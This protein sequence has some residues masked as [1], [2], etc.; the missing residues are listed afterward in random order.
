MKLCAEEVNTGKPCELL[1]IKWRKDKRIIMDDNFSLNSSNSIIRQNTYFWYKISFITF[2]TS[3]MHSSFLGNPC[4]FTF[5]KIV[6]TKD[7]K[8]ATNGRNY[9]FQPPYRLVV[10]A[11]T[12]YHCCIFPFNRISTNVSASACPS[13]QFFSTVDS[14]VRQKLDF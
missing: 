5:I 11:F 1:R 3:A 12:T 10:R 7:K 6:R 4:L 8:T 2:R 14:F 13:T 9:S